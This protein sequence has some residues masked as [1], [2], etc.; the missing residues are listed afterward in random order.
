MP[1]EPVLDYFSTLYG[2][3]TRVVL[4]GRVFT[5]SCY[6]LIVFMFQVCLIG[7]RATKDSSDLVAFV[8]AALFDFDRVRL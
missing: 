5:D 1:P 7:L 4:S 8:T 3:S 6:A 2:E